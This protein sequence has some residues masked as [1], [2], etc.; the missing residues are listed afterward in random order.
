MLSM[1]WVSVSIDQITGLHL[2][3]H[4]LTYFKV[5]HKKQIFYVKSMSQILSRIE[6]TLININ[7]NEKVIG[8]S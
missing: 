1:Y 6:R 8:T 3:P 5:K 4:K 7:Y 2:C